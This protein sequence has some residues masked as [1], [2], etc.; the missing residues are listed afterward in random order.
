MSAA[1]KRKQPKDT[2]PAPKEKATLLVDNPT[3][4][5]SW[6]VRTNQTLLMIGGFIL[7]IWIGHFALAAFVLALQIQGFRELK[8]IRDNVYFGKGKVPYQSAYLD[9]ALLF[10]MQYF[11]YGLVIFKQFQI[12]LL[13]LHPIFEIIVGYHTFISASMLIACIVAFV[14]SLKATLY[15]EQFQYITW[16]V[17]TV[18]AI[19][20]S[21]FHIYNIFQGLLWFLLP[22]SLIIC[23]DISAYI[24][25]FFFGRTSL[26]ELS[27]KKT[28]EGFIGA[29]LSTVVFSFLASLVMYG[30]IFI[31]PKTELF[32]FSSCAPHPIFIATEHTPPKLLQELL[33][34]FGIYWDSIAYA[35]VHVYAIYF[36][37][38]A[39]LVAPFGGF[40]ASGFKRALGIKDFG[41]LIPEHGGI[42][43]RMDCQVIM[44]AFSFVF[45]TNFVTAVTVTSELFNTVR[46]LPLHQQLDLLY[47]LQGA[48]QP[49]L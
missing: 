39:S 22:V 46:T 44:A 29:L 23:N 14:L 45:Y 18:I 43:D 1:T 32:G 7:I 5:K 12:E 41:D 42:V 6:W 13:S 4:W 21:N 30:D 2:E 36:G 17:M 40:L 49:Y 16:T 8:K 34:V 47:R 27:P 15:K 19:F 31:C 3:R 37:I 35:T 9:W 10:S 25:G 26:I 24:W 11:F 33:L 38:F 20:P 28:W 48:L